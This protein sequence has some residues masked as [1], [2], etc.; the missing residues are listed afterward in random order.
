MI[1][2]GIILLANRY[3]FNVGFTLAK[4]DMLVSN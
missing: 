2:I 1:K 3:Y 4:I